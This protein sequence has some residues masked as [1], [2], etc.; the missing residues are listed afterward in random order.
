MT[1]ISIEGILNGLLKEHHYWV[2]E[3]TINGANLS[4]WSEINANRGNAF[5][6][7]R[8]RLNNSKVEVHKKL[9]PATGKWRTLNLAVPED[10]EKITLL[11]ELDHEV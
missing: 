6:T 2:F 8:F 4:E 3:A 5:V 10:L 1:T 11:L 7:F 9:F